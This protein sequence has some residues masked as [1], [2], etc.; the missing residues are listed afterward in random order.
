MG[1]DFVNAVMNFRVPEM[2]VISWLAANRL[3]SQELLCSV[4][5]VNNEKR[6]DLSSSPNAN[7]EE[8]DGMARGA[9]SGGR[10]ENCVKSFDGETWRKE[11]VRKARGR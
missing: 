4:D 11:T 2:L 8:W 3:A 1:R 6:S 9:C 10:G 5:W 7:L